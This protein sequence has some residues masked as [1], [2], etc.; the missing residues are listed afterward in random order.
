MLR[1]AWAGNMQ[2][3]AAWARLRQAE[4]IADIELASLWPS[5]QANAGAEV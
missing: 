4:A 2:L 5:A 1:R 3:K